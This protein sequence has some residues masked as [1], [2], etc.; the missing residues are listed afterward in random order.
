M[1]EKL[2]A[3]CSKKDDR[4]GVRFQA[5]APVVYDQNR[6]QRAIE[7]GLEFAFR[8]VEYGG[9]PALFTSSQEQETGMKRDRNCQ[10]K[11]NK[12]QQ[13]E[14]QTSVVRPPQQRSYQQTDQS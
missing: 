10:S 8:R 1:P 11:Q 5:N 9:G 3:S 2:Q 12:D 13:D 6:V 7:D 4:R 14:R